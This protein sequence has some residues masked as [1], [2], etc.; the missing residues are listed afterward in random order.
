MARKKKTKPP[1]LSREGPVEKGVCSACG[2]YFTDDIYVWCY[3]ILCGDCRYIARTG[4]PPRKEPRTP[5]DTRE[6]H[7]DRGYDG[8]FG[9]ETLHRFRRTEV[10]SQRHAEILLEIEQE[11]AAT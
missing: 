1:D 6:L 10:V 4:Q 9:S 8:G 2:C 5:R 3:S 7:E 11:S